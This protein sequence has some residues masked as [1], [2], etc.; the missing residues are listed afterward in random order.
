MRFITQ[1]EYEKIIADDRSRTPSESIQ[2]HDE[3]S[4]TFWKMSAALKMGLSAIGT[5]HDGLGG[6]DF[7]M[8]H[9]FDDSRRLSIEVSAER[10]LSPK[11]ISII[12][13]ALQ[14]SHER[15]RVDIMHDIL[16]IPDFFLLIY[17][18]DWCAL[19]DHDFVIDTFLNSKK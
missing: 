5:P 7:W 12:Q 15:W 19:G 17:R 14:V 9:G 11:M 8:N 10:I 3:Y 18:D 16:G 4:E 1:G 13:E 2:S 6:G